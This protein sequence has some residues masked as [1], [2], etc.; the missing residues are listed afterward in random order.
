MSE[1][2][3]RAVLN[4]LIETCRDGETGFRDAAAHVGDPQLKALFLDIASQRADFVAKLMPHAERLGGDSAA[5]GTKAAALHRGWMHIKGLLSHDSDHAIVVEAERGENAAL[6]AYKEAVAVMLPPDVRDIVEQQYAEI[7]KSHT[8][9]QA[10][11]S[12]RRK[13]S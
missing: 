2:T 10:A 5:E 7:Q 13:H 3:A 12:A 11:E 8:R 1:M 9:I 6:T 4:H